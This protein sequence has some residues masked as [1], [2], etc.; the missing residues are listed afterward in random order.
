M[1]GKTNAAPTWKKRYVAHAVK[2][3]GSAAQERCSFCFED[4]LDEIGQGM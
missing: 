1:C 2:G 3:L 4:H